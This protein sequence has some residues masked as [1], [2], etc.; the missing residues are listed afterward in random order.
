[1]APVPPDAWP[2][3]TYV[4]GQKEMH[5]NH[6][7]IEIKWQPAAISDGDSLVFFRRSDV[8]VA[9]D[10][11]DMTSYPKNR[12]RTRRQHPGRTRRAE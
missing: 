7:P 2:T 6:E 8:V 4:S 10:I 1:V 11:F 3:M 9:G 12:S 5:F